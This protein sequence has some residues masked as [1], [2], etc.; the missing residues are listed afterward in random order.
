MAEPIIVKE[1]SKFEINDSYLDKLQAY[2]K[3]AGLWGL[4]FLTALQN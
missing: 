1:Y 2:L 3:S 4:S